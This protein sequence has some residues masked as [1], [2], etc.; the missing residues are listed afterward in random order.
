MP[1]YLNE[2]EGKQV[3][4][5]DHCLPLSWHDIVVNC[6]KFNAESAFLQ[7]SHEEQVGLGYPYLKQLEGKSWP[8]AAASWALKIW[9]AGAFLGLFITYAIGSLNEWLIAIYVW[10]G[11]IIFITGKG[12]VPNVGTLPFIIKA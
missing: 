4:P 7:M 1:V 6:K 9:F 3:F 10:L 2:E 11:I 8:H 12:R 5:E